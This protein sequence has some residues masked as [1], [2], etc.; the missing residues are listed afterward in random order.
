MVGNDGSGVEIR[1]KS[2]ITQKGEAIA[3]PLDL[4]LQTPPLL[5][6]DDTGTLNQLG[7]NVL[8]NFAVYGSVVWGARPL[9]GADLI[10]SEWKYINVRRTADYIEDSLVGS[11]KWVVF[12][13]N[14]E[15]LWANI[16][17]EV[18]SF[19]AGLFADGAFAGETPDKAYLVACDSTTT[20][21]TDIDNGIVNIL[22]GF[23]PLYPAEFVF[24][25]LEQLTAS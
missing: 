7:A 6:D 14:D 2:V 3:E 8:R 1:R 25:Q 11:L 17:A 21:Q 16:R 9:A 12:E 13:N 15:R 24:I 22:V 23:A 4:V 19:M 20:T 18:G 10:D 5:N